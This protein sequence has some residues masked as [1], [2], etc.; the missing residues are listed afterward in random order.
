[1]TTTSSPRDAFTACRDAQIQ[2]AKR[3]SPPR[4]GNACSTA[5]WPS[6]RRT[7]WPPTLRCARRR[8]RDAWH[9]VLTELHTNQGVPMSTRSALHAADPGGYAAAI[10]RD[11]DRPLAE[12]NSHLDREAFRILA[13]ADNVRERLT[14]KSPP[15]PRDPAIPAARGAVAFTGEPS[16]PVRSQNRA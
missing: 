13:A 6:G 15:A 12:N 8:A 16:C 11:T 14:R 9:A 2:A 3:P 7:R 4:S 1:M 10:S 5:S